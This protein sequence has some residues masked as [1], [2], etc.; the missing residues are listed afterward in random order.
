MKQYYFV[1][2]FVRNDISDYGGLQGD[3]GETKK[4]LTVERKKQ[5]NLNRNNKGP[6]QHQLANSIER[7]FPFGPE[8]IPV[9][10]LSLVTC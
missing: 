7:I 2:D 4:Q 6:D 10:I 1:G 5:Y 3:C 8:E 9:R